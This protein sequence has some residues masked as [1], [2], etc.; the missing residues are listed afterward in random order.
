[1]L[2]SIQFNLVC[3][4]LSLLLQPAGSRCQLILLLACLWSHVERKFTDWC[5]LVDDPTE[6]V[7]FLANCG[8]LFGIRRQVIA[9]SFAGLSA[10]L[11]LNRLGWLLRWN[12]T[13]ILSFIFSWR[14]SSEKFKPKW[15]NWWNQNCVQKSFYFSNHQKTT[16]TQLNS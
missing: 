10:M 7:Q 13:K 14:S 3:F 11:Y 2:Q 15:E 12:R 16:Q 5:Y 9:V 4:M 1:M 6:L 8:E